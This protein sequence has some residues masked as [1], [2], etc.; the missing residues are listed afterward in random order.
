MSEL[1]NLCL[2][3]VFLWSKLWNFY[4][5]INLNSIEVGVLRKSCCRD[6]H[7][8]A[9]A[10]SS[11]LSSTITNQSTCT[12]FIMQWTWWLLWVRIEWLGELHLSFLPGSPM[13]A[14]LSWSQHPKPSGSVKHF[15]GG[16]F[17]VRFCSVS[18]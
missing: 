13:T 5:K 18:R 12:T 16:F 2:K 15:P 4:L 9:Q 3:S 17:W 7:S 6:N 8:N 10:T 1:T 14:H 11:R